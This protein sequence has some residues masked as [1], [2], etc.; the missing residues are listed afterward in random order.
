[1]SKDNDYQNVRRFARLPISYRVQYKELY[2][3]IDTSSLRSSK[4]K[5]FSPG[6]LQ[7]SS[8]KPG[9][10]ADLVAAA[11][12]YFTATYPKEKV[13]QVTVAGNWFVAKQNIFGQPIQWG[14][15]IYCASQQSEPGIC[16]VFKSSVLTGTG[17]GIA[18]APP[19]T[20]HW[21]SDSYRMLNSNLK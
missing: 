12:K 7:F 11:Q 17:L 3:R 1:L 2:N 5:N 16:R 10:P 14:L 13:L 4:L 15:P 21:T 9:K 19:F 18:K 8:S 6:G 20:D